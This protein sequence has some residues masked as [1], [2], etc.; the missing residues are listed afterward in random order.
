MAEARDY[1]DFLPLFP[2]EDEETI[3]A[4]WRGW[5][6]EGLDPLA[7][8]TEWTD[9][10]EGSFWH[11]VT[12]PGVRESALLYE[13]MTEA[14][15][16]GMILYSWGEYLDDHAEALGAARLAAT[17]A[18]GDAV[19]TGDPGTLI[20]EG[21]SITTEPAAP[22]DEPPSFAVTRAGTIDP[23]LDAPTGLTATAFDGAGTLAAATYYYVVT[24]LDANGQTLPSAEASVA[25]VAPA[26]T[27][28]LAW[29]AVPG[30]VEYRVYRGTATG[31][32]YGL[33]GTTTAATYRD[34]GTAAGA[35]PPATNTT[36]GTTV[37]LPVRATE[38]GTAGNLAAGALTVMET[39]IPGVTVSNPER[40]L[41]GTEV[42]SDAALVARLVELHNDRGG[43]TAQRYRTWA[44]EQEGVGAATVVPLFAGAG[45]VLVVVRTAEGAPVSAENVTELWNRLD[46]PRASTELT[47][48]VDL[49]VAT[50]PVV[51][52]EGFRTSGYVSIGDELV[53]HTGVTA[54]SFTG[55]T[56][57]TAA[58]PVGEPVQE[59][60][61]GGGLAPVGHH[62][63]VR[64]AT[65]LL[66]TVAATVEADVGYSL[67]GTGGTTPIRT[68]I[69]NALRDYVERVEPGGEV[70][71]ARVIGVIAGTRGVHDVGAVTINGAAVNLAVSAYPA[72]APVLATPTLTAGTL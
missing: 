23:V 57:G 69:V 41:G 46:P 22:E 12:M 64:T 4:R 3:L 71:L 32:P 53:H 51:S 70:V 67:D 56:G 8:A 36:G 28:D 49:P 35:A 16:A 7:D 42:Q 20:P 26:D 33:I 52:T 24:A 34:T 40:M 17:A 15:A 72:Q 25:V 63:V 61:R 43:A 50:L 31:G 47:A 54:T 19:F 68:A 65:D 48:A 30:A 39:P 29:T 60:G 1:L 6:N 62:V 10:R 45:T 55:C 5:A 14:A 11:V 13:R 2:E 66:V 21:T 9:T 59:R 18:A 27:V 44:L 37:T 58:Y 38:P